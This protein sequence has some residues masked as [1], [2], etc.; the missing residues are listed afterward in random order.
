MVKLPELPTHLMGG[1]DAATLTNW[2]VNGV[3]DVPVRK[4]SVALKLLEEVFELCYASGATTDEVRIIWEDAERKAIDQ[5]MALGFYRHENVVDEVG[6]VA[7]TFSN[8]CFNVNVQPAATV[9]LTVN[10]ILARSWYPDEFGILRR[11]K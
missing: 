7:V 4:P 2:V 8:Y 9:N 1:H 3:G 10:K 11:H 5:R 6:D